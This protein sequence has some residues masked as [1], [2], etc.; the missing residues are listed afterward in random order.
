MKWWYYDW[1]FEVSKAATT[2]LEIVVNSEKGY[3]L[4]S[5]VVMFSRVRNI[6]L[7]LGCTTVVHL[8]MLKNG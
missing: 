5:F 4:I 3:R 2:L 6:C 7:F 1:V 8:K